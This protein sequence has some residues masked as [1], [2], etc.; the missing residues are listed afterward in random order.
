[1]IPGDKVVSILTPISAPSSAPVPKIA[2]DPVY[3][4][5][6]ANVVD[7]WIKAGKPQPKEN[8][9]YSRL[10][11]AHMQLKVM[12]GALALSAEL[13]EAIRPLMPAF[14][15]VTGEH[16]EQWRKVVDVIFRSAAY[17]DKHKL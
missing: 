11:E 5:I 17:A 16:R 13:V 2:N 7:A 10:V 15:S 1:M 4:V 6:R 12:D 9:M 8:W 14:D 3:G